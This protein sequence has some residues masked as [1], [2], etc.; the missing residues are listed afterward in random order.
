MDI[1]LKRGTKAR[2][3]ALDLLLLPGEIGIETDTN[4]FKI[5]DGNLNWNQ[6]EYSAKDLTVIDEQGDIFTGVNRLRFTGGFKATRD[7]NDPTLITVDGKGTTPPSPVI[8]KV[9]YG[10]AHS[11]TL[12]SL[13]IK[14]L[15]SKEVNSPYIA[16]KEDQTGA[17]NYFYIAIP[18][19]YAD[20]VGKII[21]IP[22]SLA[23]NWDV[24]ETQIDSE[25]FKVFRSPFRMYDNSVTFKTER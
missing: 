7:Q 19:K 2:W 4:R 11:E 17:P 24:Y 14:R 18:K 22:G 3:K 5:G 1:Q 15:K 25:N 16:F 23:A 9:Y 20:S 6:L 10:F 13:D 12:V 21:Q 8:F